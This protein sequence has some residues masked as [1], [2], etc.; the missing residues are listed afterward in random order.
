MSGFIGIINFDGEPID[1]K[2]LEGLAKRIAYM[3]PDSL[4]FLIDGAAGF[5]HALFRTTR[6]SS[7]EQQPLTID[8]STIVGDARIDARDELVYQ[9]RSRGQEVSLDLPDINLILMAYRVWNQSCLQYL[10]GDFAFAIWDRRRRQVYCAR[11]HFGIRPLYYAHI[12]TSLI[13]SNQIGAIRLHPKVTPTLNE[14]Y[15]ADFLLC[16]N[17][18]WLDR[19]SSA[20]A[21]IH[22]IPPAHHL[23]CDGQ[24]VKV[25]SYWALPTTGSMLKYRSENE[26]ISHFM[27]LLKGAVKDRLRSE[28]AVISMSGGLDSTSLA[29]VAC[30]LVKSGDIETKLT[31]HTLV[32][33]R[34]H[35]DH[36]AYYAALAARSIGIPIHI[37][38]RDHLLL[39]EPL[40][41][42]AEPMLV[43]QSVASEEEAQEDV[44]SG[45][46]VLQ[47]HGVDELLEETPL[48]QIVASLGLREGTAL[49]LWLWRFIGHRPAL[50]GLRRFVHPRQWREIPRTP[51]VE[52]PI[53]FNP[54]LE[55]RLELR[56]RWHEFW[57]W[58]PTQ[59][60]FLHPI[61]FKSTILP[62]RTLRGELLHPPLKVSLEA[63]AP[64]LDL[65]L[66]NF[67]MS[68]P[69]QPWFTRKYLLR[70]AMQDLLPAEI[71]A[72]PKTILGS[73]LTSL[74][75]Q[76]GVDW[77]DRWEAVGELEAYV[78]RAAVPVIAGKPSEYSA[79]FVNLR[80]LFLNRWLLSRN[81]IYD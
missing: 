58:K 47:G 42:M 71:L 24:T 54:D 2:L 28:R 29:A 62:D 5:S 53:W 72:R 26:Y 25:E 57:N 55:Q 66:V 43:M 51:P 75:Q 49:F 21:D 46:V 4:S 81:S 79:A 68:L 60:H 45:A 36:E 52:F 30:Q 48:Y 1:K 41:T 22:R 69:P 3:G 70:R 18:I 23:I 11:D 67:I 13:V 63:T 33:D 10:I 32:Y 12:G 19:A 35:P 27:Q 31:A 77:I 56:A 17:Q 78:N 74:L 16:G 44:P 6:E 37:S 9:L 7:T 59:P 65:R 80:P 39:K 76:P 64:F 50:G 40:P 14:R 20:F 15:I 61:A 38:S 8:E 34:I 73:L